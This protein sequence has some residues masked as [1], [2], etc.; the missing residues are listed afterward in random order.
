MVLDWYG[1][2]GYW[3]GTGFLLRDA[4]YW[5]DSPPQTCGVIVLK[6]EE[7]AR[8]DL[9]SC[10]AILKSFPIKLILAKRI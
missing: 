2:K 3:I 1:L 7:V 6:P 4:W 10:A 5:Y 9:F 8:F